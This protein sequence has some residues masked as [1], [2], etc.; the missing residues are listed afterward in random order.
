MRRN[1]ASWPVQREEELR[2]LWAKGYSSSAI[3]HEFCMSRSA[4]C[5]KVARMGLPEHAVVVKG[6]CTRAE[7]WIPRKSKP[8]P[9]IEDAPAK[10]KKVKAKAAN[11]R[12]T[13]EEWKS[14]LAEAVRNT[15]GKG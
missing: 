15:G 13:R 6:K 2:R 7:A 10:K 12:R 14:I 11:G 4:I 5:G 3:A 1:K 9:W 8:P